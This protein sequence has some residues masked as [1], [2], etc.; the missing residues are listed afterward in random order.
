MDGKETDDTNSS[1]SKGPFIKEIYNTTIGFILIP[2]LQI[3][4]LERLY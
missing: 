4:N 3:L 1:K 2:I